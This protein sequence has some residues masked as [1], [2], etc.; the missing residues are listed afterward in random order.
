LLRKLAVEA[1]ASGTLSIRSRLPSP[2]PSTARRRKVDGMN[3]VWP[4]APAH[5]PTSRS[6][7]MSPASRIFS[8]LRNSPR[9]NACR[10]P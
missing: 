7:V 6:G 3:W 9:K 8:V 2:S 10:R 4:K 5:E 1:R